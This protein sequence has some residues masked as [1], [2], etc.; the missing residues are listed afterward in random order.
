MRFVATPLASSVPQPEQRPGGVDPRVLEAAVV[1]PCMP[2]AR[3]RLLAPGTVVITT[4]QQ[5]GLFTGPLYTVYKALSATA[6]ARQLEATWDVPVVPVFW[7]ATDDH[8][9]AEAATAAWPAPDGTVRRVTLRERPA[10]APLTPMYRE[11]LGPEVAAVLE[12]LEADLQGDF[13]GETMAWLR[14]HYHPDATVGQ[15]YA[16]A[17]AELLCPW[18]VVC[19]DAGS[20]ALKRLAA[21]WLLR[22]LQGARGLNRDLAALSD[23]LVAAGADPGVPVAPDATLVM[24][25]GSA[26]R[27]RLVLEGPDGF[28]TRRGGEVFSLAELAG[29]A[30]E[31]PERFSPNVLLRPVVESALLPT[32]AYVAGPG[33]LR[34]LALAKAVYQGLEVPRQ[35]PVPRW[36]GVVV[37]AR[38]DRVM[39]KFGLG[40]HDLLGPPGALERSLARDQ[41]P[42][43]LGAG[44]AQLRAELERRYGEVATGAVAIDPTL[45][46]TVLGA[47]GQALHGLAEIE[48]KLVQHLRRRS[49]T[50]LGQVSRVRASLRPDGKPQERVLTLAP[51]LARYGKAFLDEMLASATQW[52][53]GAL[54]HAGTRS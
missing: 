2:E 11:V 27:D 29:L 37:D 4:G 21:P 49:E 22:A 51:F 23:H 1:G 20:V 48:R 17:M 36:S 53:A 38:A 25:E 6:L 7:L 52:Y 9:F 40:L 42:S 28:R 19:L 13:A 31:F 54:E 34:Y 3:Q 35:E 46:K 32:S 26:G 43:D 14:R 15:A 45:E 44:I 16:Q 41:L 5:P 39:G 8:D 10:D 33:E 12:V 30:A 18:G 47:R 50:E 24:L